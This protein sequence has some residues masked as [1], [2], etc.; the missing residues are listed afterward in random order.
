MAFLQDHLGDVLPVRHVLR[1]DHLGDDHQNHHVRLD[2]RL[3]RQLLQL[4]GSYSLVS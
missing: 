4:L 3:E 1:Q 2:E